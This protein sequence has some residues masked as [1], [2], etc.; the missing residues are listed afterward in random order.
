MQ[1][2]GI[3]VPGKEYRGGSKCDVRANRQCLFELSQVLR[4][5]FKALRPKKFE[6]KFSPPSPG[7]DEVRRRQQL[8]LFALKPFVPSN[9]PLADVIAYSRAHEIFP[10]RRC[11]NPKLS[12]SSLHRC[13]N[14][15]A[16]P[17]A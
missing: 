5:E 12:R 13:S 16:C 8:Y 14:G 17:P 15:M 2:R 3:R 9:E 6:E 1:A 10:M 4:A 7:G 11:V